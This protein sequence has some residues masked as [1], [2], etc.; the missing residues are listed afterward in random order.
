MS[1]PAQ[2]ITVGHT[3]AL[4]RANTSETVGQHQRTDEL[5]SR[6]HQSLDQSQVPQNLPR[7]FFESSVPQHNTSPN[8]L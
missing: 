5:V 1:L 7:P 6:L 4:Q 2:H 3:Q 8:I